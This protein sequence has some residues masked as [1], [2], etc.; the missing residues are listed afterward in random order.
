M[1][2][3]IGVNQ[4]GFGAQI[5][6]LPLYAQSFG[7]TQFD[8]GLS[9][10]VYGAAR[11]VLGV[12]TG[13]VADRFG[14]R[15]ALALGGLVSLVGNV[16]TATASTFPELVVA[17][18]VS[19]AGA[20]LVLNAGAIVL[21]DISTPERRGR[22]MAMYQGTFLFAVGIGPLPGGLLAEQ[23]GLG[24]P[25]WVYAGLSFFVGLIAWF[26]VAETRDLGRKT[27]T[28][29][30]RDSIWAQLWAL[31]LMRGF[32]LVCSV[33]FT[34]ALTRTGAL[35]AIVPILMLEQI[36]LSA[37]EIGVGMALGSIL[38]LLVTY[39]AGALADRFG[40]KAVIVP[41]NLLTGIS[42]AL[43]AF[44]PSYGWYLL[45]S[46]LWGMASAAGGAAPAAYAADCAPAGQN[47]AAMS[48]YRSLSDSGYVLG[49][50]IF[51]L[52]ADWAGAVSALYAS[53]VLLIIV[54]LTFMLRAP[55]TYRGART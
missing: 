2:V 9:V 50:L 36:G 38:G 19:G 53:C 17:R 30:R 34:Q 8:I 49:P 37:A 24:A 14:R 27:S 48:A 18:F 15:H 55:E 10:A 42:M 5:P 16:W 35:F 1:C 25:F 21:A 41:A 32:R 13:Q 43:F 4:L 3:L 47:A 31:M 46:T 7:V 20:A 26:A 52:A 11:F 22:M 40:R 29:G 23:Y 39:P 6:V 54:A 33:G 51:G 45:G 28:A 12:P 44:A